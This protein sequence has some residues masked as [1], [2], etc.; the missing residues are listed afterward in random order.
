MNAEIFPDIEKTV[1]PVAINGEKKE[2]MHSSFTVTASC[3]NMKCIE[4]W[5]S[6]QVNSRLI[7]V[8]IIDDISKV[9]NKKY[10]TD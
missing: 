8:F 9:Q 6:F 2:L 5:I 7:K 4:Y 10:K 1:A 3:I